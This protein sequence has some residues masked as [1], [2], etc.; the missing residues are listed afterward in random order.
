MGRMDEGFTSDELK[1]H[2]RSFK[3]RKEEGKVETYY[4]ATGEKINEGNIGLA[5]I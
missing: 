3:N 5:K 4:E 1:R 2:I